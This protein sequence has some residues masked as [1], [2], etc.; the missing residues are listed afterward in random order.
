MSTEHVHVSAHDSAVLNRIFNPNLPYGD[1]V[2]EDEVDNEIGSKT[3]LFE[4][5]SQGFVTIYLSSII[6]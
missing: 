3:T 4:V 1:V 2:D 5:I 6:N